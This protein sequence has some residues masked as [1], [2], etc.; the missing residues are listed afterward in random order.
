M[1]LTIRRYSR[2]NDLFT[3]LTF[4]DKN[5]KEV[6]YISIENEV[7]TVL[8]GE[9]A[10]KTLTYLMGQKGYFPQTKEETVQLTI[11]IPKYDDFVFIDSPVTFNDAD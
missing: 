11:N 4:V 3:L 9:Q 5:G 7:P 6:Q 2:D 8:T 10:A 1:H